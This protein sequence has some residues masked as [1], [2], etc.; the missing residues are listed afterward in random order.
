MTCHTG[1][2]CRAVRHP[3]GKLSI[4]LTS[5]WL[6]L[7]WSTVAL[8]KRRPSPRPIGAN[9]ALASLE[10]RGVR[11][12]RAPRPF[13]WDN[14]QL[15]VKSDDRRTFQYRLLQSWYRGIILGAQALM[16]LTEIPRLCSPEFPTCEVWST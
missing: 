6:R 7:A 3:H 15:A 12:R 13:R 1:A 14:P 11:F 4:G 9:A 10:R 8:L 16:A 2:A 5:L